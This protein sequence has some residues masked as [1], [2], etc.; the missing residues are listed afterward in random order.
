MQPLTGDELA[1]TMVA[2]TPRILDDLCPECWLPT[3]FE[4]D[5][6]AVTGRGVSLVA[7]V[8]A[9]VECDDPGP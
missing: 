6:H 5:V 4:V 1:V 7:T 8:L 3:L 2:G 9:C